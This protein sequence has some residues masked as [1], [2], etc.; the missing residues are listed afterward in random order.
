MLCVL[1]GLV[2]A[3]PATAASAVSSPRRPTQA[4]GLT[5]FD[6]FESAW[7][8]PEPVFDRYLRITAGTPL[9]PLPPDSGSGRRIVYALTDQMVWLVAADETIL[10]NYLVSGRL[11]SPGPG[12]YEV[13]S[14]SRR[15]VAFL[16][17]SI[18]MRWMVRFAT[19]DKTNLGFHDL[20]RYGDGRPMQTEEELGT[21]LSGGCVRQADA[22]AI[23]MYRW[24]PVGT[25]VIVTP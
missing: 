23:R 17:Q 18:T 24:A 9:A 19:T 21:A 7:A 1:V 3:I 14:K 15:T 20:P 6:T 10:A 25:P 2:V 4:A 8:V 16:D 5:A 13:F 22:D 11:G 12:T